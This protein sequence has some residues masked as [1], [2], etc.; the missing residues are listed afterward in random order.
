MLGKTKLNLLRFT[1]ILVF[2]FSIGKREELFENLA[3]EIVVKMG[4]VGVS[5]AIGLIK[6]GVFFYD[7]ISYPVY[8]ILQRPWQK[9]RAMN[10]DRAYTVPTSDDELCY[11]GIQP[12]TELQVEFKRNKITTLREALDYAFKKYA[13]KKALGTRKILSEF[14]EVQ[15]NGKVFKKYDMG[16]YS[17]ITY[18]ELDEMSLWFGRGLRVLGHEPKENLIIF[19][20]TRYE[21]LVCAAGAFRQS[22]A[23][24]TLYATLGDDAVVHGIN[25]TEVRHI[26]TSH[27]LLPKLRTILP[28]C[29]K[30]TRV[31]YFGDQLKPTDV[32]GYK[33]GVVFTSFNEILDKGK[34]ADYAD[35]PPAPS[36][37]AIIMYTSGSTGNPKGVILSHQNLVESVLAYSIVMQVRPNDV[38]LA[39]LPLAHVLELMAETIMLLY[40]LP[41]GYS[42]PLTMTDRSTKVKR[43]TPGDVSVLK[44]T[45]MPAVPLILDRIYK[46]ILEKVAAQGK[47][48]EALFQYGLEYKNKWYRRGWGTPI[49]NWFVFRK[50]RALMGG[51][52]RLIAAGG[53]P[54]PPDTHDFIRSALGCPVLQGYGLTESC[55]CATLMDVEDLSTG[56]V[57]APLSVC[58]IKIVNWEEGNYRSSDKPNPRGEVIIG[59]NNIALGYYKNPEQTAQDFYEMDGKRWFRTGDIGE[60]ERDGCLKIIDRKKD[61]VKLQFGEYVS[62]GKVEAELKVSPLVENLCLYGDPSRNNTVAI[63]SPSV[64][65]L[66]EVAA[67]LGL[68]NDAS[69]ETLCQDQGVKAAVL[70]DLAATAK[71]AKLMRFEIPTAVHLTPDLWTPDSGLVTAAFKLKRRAVE[72]RYLDDIRRMYA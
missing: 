32:T 49:C 4:D 3:V 54:L 36:D 13:E 6:V 50:I 5:V 52:V 64:R 21:W 24:C 47:F 11:R 14:D 23:M 68:P 16:D 70:E 72:S 67:K 34:K 66:R 10:K 56:R 46:G 25:E 31:I 29:P 33:E 65:A 40:G 26:V 17:W 41:M 58:D 38:Y 8:A 19:S 48:I 7:V 2:F 9:R 45:L 35:V 30:V 22:V 15:K 12:V 55:G 43:G 53:A 61:L 28:L 44:P 69:V 63:V 37:P 1:N 18:A 62:L 39:Y 27:D 60:I 42:T 71:K 59:G 57:G 20:E 51:R